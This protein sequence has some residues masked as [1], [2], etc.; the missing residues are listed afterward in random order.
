M[1]F[2]ALVKLIKYF[3]GL[4]IASSNNLKFDIIIN[5][6]INYKIYIYIYIHVTVC[7]IFIDLQW[8]SLKLGID[9]FIWILSHL[10]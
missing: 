1:I 10:T 9:L 6:I 5:V 4:T 8:A 3:Y 2:N 7:E